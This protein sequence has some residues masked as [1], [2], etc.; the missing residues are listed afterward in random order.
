MAHANVIEGRG[1]GESL[2]CRAE[3]VRPLFV[4]LVTLNA[5]EGD[6]SFDIGEGK[7]VGF[8]VG[9]IGGQK[10]GETSAGGMSADKNSIGS[11]AV[12]GDVTHGPS[13]SAGQILDV[14]RMLYRRRKAIA[15]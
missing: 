13:K 9:F 11:T 14:S 7:F 8:Q 1:V 3:T 10:S 5:A 2:G 6:H 12:V 15:D 4:K